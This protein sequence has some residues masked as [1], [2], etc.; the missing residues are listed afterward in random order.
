MV[1]WWLAHAIFAGGFFL[2]SYGVVQAF[3]TTRSFATIYSQEEWMA[4]L[5]A[6]MGR[7]E[8]ALQALKRTN[9][10]LEHLAATDPLTGAANRRT[11]MRRIEAE[12]ASAKRE[13]ESF[14][15]LALDLD[16]F[17]AVNDR[18]GYQVGDEV[19]QGFVRDAATQFAPMTA[20]PASVARNLWFCC[21]VSCP[22][23]T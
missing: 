11:F 6:A 16:N 4:R 22:A 15:L 2:L 9:Q 12:I 21:L 3:H 14:S 8:S 17:K 23:N 10:K 7:T 19:L 13:G 5:A 20:L 18:Y 1:I